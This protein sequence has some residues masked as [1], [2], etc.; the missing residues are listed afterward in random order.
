MNTKIAVKI[1]A[2]LLIRASLALQHLAID[3]AET[4]V[5]TEKYS[6]RNA[7][8]W[9]ARYKEARDT[10]I[11]FDKEAHFSG[12]DF[13]QLDERMDAIMEEAEK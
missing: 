6:K 13:S 10:S 12:F 7:C 11:A 5:R 3:H 4:A 1:D 2:V 9:V 8:F